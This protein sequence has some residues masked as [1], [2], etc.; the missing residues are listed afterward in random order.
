VYTRN[1]NYE[2]EKRRLILIKSIIEITVR[3][4]ELHKFTTNLRIFRAT[5]GKGKKI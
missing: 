1:I 3:Y 4:K 5:A 2:I